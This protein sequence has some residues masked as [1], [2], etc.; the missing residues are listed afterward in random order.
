MSWLIGAFSTVA[1]L[2]AIA[3]I[4]GVISYSVGQRTQEISVRMA[5]GLKQ[6]TC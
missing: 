6:K 4:Y 2:L 3:G 1:F 5:M